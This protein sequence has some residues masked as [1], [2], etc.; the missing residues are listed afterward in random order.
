M[1]QNKLRRTIHT[2]EAVSQS[3]IKLISMKNRISWLFSATFGR[4]TA[5]DFNMRIKG[6]KIPNNNATDSLSLKVIIKQ[7][8]NRIIYQKE[9]QLSP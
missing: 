9:L 2:F 4:Y 6:G 7:V 1:R 3:G 5:P 8:L